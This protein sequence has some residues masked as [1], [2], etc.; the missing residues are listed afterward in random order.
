MPLGIKSY[1][2]PPKC[3]PHRSPYAISRPLLLRLQKRSQKRCGVLHIACR[4]KPGVSSERVGILSVTEEVI[5]LGVSAK[6]KDGE[7]NKAV[8]ELIAQVFYL[9]IP[10][11]AS[12]FQIPNIGT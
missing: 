1:L 9:S 4:V 8:I 7:A 2:S 11:H 10:A 6:A 5:E 12:T 3:H